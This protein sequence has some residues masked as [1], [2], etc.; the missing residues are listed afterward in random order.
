M[1]HKLK[2]PK[3][4]HKGKPKKV[5]KKTTKKAAKSVKKPVKK[6]KAVKEIDTK[7]YPSFKLRKEDDIAMDF[8][9][10]VY[11]RF[12]KIIKSVVLFGSAAKETAV[13]GSDIDI[14]VI[15]D[16]VT[17]KWDQ[18]LIAWYRTELEKILSENPYKQSLHIN[19]IKLSTWWEDLIRGDPVVI[20]ILRYGEAMIDLAGFFNPLKFLLVQGKIK[21]TPEAIYSCL[22]RAPQHLSRSRASQINSIEGLYWSMVDSAHAAL[23]AA[24]IPPASPEHIPVDLK[25]NFVDTG[26]IKMKYVLW[27]RDLLILHKKISHGDIKEL[28]GVE[29]DE[30]REKAEEFLRVMAEL[31]KSIVDKD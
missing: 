22:K 31:V 21:S 14:V 12:N 3:L 11:E 1:K 19:T 25:E 8:A 9:T 18:E 29:I 4:P 6:T 23:I 10:K 28:K 2:L 30:W 15:I 5:V 20:N 17:I 7:K 26:R 16:D 24:N 13:A 27:Y